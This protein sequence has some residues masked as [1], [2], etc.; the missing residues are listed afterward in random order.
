MCAQIGLEV[1]ELGEGTSAY[2]TLTAF[3]AS[4]F[5]IVDARPFAGTISTPS[6]L[7]RVPPLSPE[8]DVHSLYRP[9]GHCV[10]HNAALTTR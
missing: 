3:I 1:C 5:E 9:W 7:W 10:Q 2:G 8:D 4:A 6:P